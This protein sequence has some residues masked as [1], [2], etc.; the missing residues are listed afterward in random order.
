MSIRMTSGNPEQLFM[1]SAEIPLMHFP[2][3]EDHT[4][5]KWCMNRHGA[6]R[7]LLSSLV[8]AYLEYQ[9]PLDL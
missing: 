7:Y 9:G 8:L 2:L 1:F 4:G 5:G 6:L 3:T